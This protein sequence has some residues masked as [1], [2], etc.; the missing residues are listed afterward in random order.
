MPPRKANPTPRAMNPASLRSAG[1]TARATTSSTR[2]SQPFS[3]NQ[4]GTLLRRYLAQFVAAVDTGVSL[5]TDPRR[6][7]RSGAAQDAAQMAA[8]EIAATGAAMPAQAQQPPPQNRQP[9]G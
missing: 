5:D 4:T 6:V 2:A 1:L 8:V 3:L 7:A 9:Q